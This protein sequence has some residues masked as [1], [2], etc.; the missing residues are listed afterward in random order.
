MKECVLKPGEYVDID[1]LTERRGST[2]RTVFTHLKECGVSNRYNYSG[3]GV[4]S[5]GRCTSGQIEYVDKSLYHG[6]IFDTYIT[7]EEFERRL[8]GTTE[9]N[10]EI[11]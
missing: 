11:Y 3:N 7:Y 5:I 9:P 6:T 2:V 8:N 1:R 10:Y 4:S